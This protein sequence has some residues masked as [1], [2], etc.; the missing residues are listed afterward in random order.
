MD[1]YVHCGILTRYQRRHLRLW[2]RNR[3]MELYLQFGYGMMQHCRH[4][5]AD[6]GGG[7]VVLSP[8]D[9]SDRQL[10]TLSSE[11]TDL[12]GGRVLLDPQFYLPHADHERL[13]SH[14]YWPTD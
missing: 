14:D 3:L 4:L 1:L 7:T 12:P 10:R 2:T 8:R 5:I 13:R 9:M 6:W 11:I